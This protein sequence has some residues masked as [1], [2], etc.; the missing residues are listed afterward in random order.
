[1]CEEL[2][3]RVGGWLGL[4]KIVDSILRVI[5]EGYYYWIVLEGVVEDRLILVI[6]LSKGRNGG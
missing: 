6:G 1:M 4:W 3:V 2:G 5:G